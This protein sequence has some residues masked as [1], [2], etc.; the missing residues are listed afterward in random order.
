MKKKNKTN[1]LRQMQVRKKQESEH[2]VDDI[3]MLTDQIVKEILECDPKNI[4]KDIFY[5]KLSQAK[6]G[7]DYL[8]D[9]EIMKR[10]SS[11]HM[12]RVINFIATDPEEKLAY[13]NASVPEITLTKQI[14]E[15]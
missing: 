7:R 6:L 8:K 2:D 9:R 5:M 15:K 11:G 10:I 14:E 13:I 1:E 3:R 12:I 4:E